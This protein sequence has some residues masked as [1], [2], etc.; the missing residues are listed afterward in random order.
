MVA[1]PK[2]APG[3]YVQVRYMKLEPASGFEPLAVR[4]QGGWANRLLQ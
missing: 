1:D 3:T 4:L 2:L